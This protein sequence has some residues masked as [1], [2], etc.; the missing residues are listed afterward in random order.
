[1]FWHFFNFFVCSIV[2]ELGLENYC[3][4]TLEWTI[5]LLAK[6]D[7]T[8]TTIV[9]IIIIQWTY[10]AV[11]RVHKDISQKK[12]QVV[13]ENRLQNS[14]WRWRKWIFSVYRTDAL[15]CAGGINWLQRLWIILL[16]SQ[17][18]SPG[19]PHA[20]VHESDMLT[21]VCVSKY[22]SRRGWFHAL[23]DF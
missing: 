14:E 9:Y 7:P 20:F 18:L 2:W 23:K 19:L 21:W 1:M 5:F 12:K 22:S 16:I 3:H 13:S 10:K 17:Y 15:Y 4:H 6:E 8:T 11:F